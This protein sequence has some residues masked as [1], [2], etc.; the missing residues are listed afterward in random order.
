MH[1]LIVDDHPLLR[2]GVRQL[3]ATAYPD[4]SIDDVETLAD[5]ASAFSRR[6]ADAVILDLNLPDAYGIEGP[7]RMLRIAGDVPILVLSQNAESG[8]AAQLFKLGIRGYV[9]KDRAPTELLAALRRVL[10]GGRYASAELVDR[11]VSLLE[12][13]TE[14]PGLPHQQLTTQEFRV[15]QLIAAGRT[16]ADIA[17]VMHISPK[18]VGSYRA[19]ILKKT[20]WRSTAE[21]AKYCVQHGLTTHA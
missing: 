1:F 8:A 14:G 16:P 3:L 18:T 19:R 13:R 10:G 12:G 5:A 4:C 20:G 2:M 9:Q 11:L 6:P 15:M 21:L 7:A 17:R